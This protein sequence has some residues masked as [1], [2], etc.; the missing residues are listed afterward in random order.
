MQYV[1]IIEFE[2]YMIFYIGVREKERRKRRERKKERACSGGREEEVTMII[3]SGRD[4]S[5]W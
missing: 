1:Y 3:F 2:D 5:L 4:S